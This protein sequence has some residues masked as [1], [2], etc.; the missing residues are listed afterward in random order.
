[1]DKYSISIQWSDEDKG[2]I[3]TVPELKGLSAF[4]TSKDEA[5]NELQIAKKA[6]LEVF[7]EDGC[8]LPEP[9]LLK[10]YSGQFRLRLPKS[11]HAYL[12]KKAEKED[13]SLNTLIISALSEG[14]N[15]ESIVAILK[16]GF[17]GLKEEI[18]RLHILTDYLYQKEVSTSCDIYDQKQPSA[19][20][21]SVQGLVVYNS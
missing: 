16:E 11:L 6:Y 2:Y 8:E 13:V 12:S 3:A 1:M 5:F 20:L 4:G 15:N 19:F 7:E 9:D 21:N 17:A 18:T 10:D 14:S